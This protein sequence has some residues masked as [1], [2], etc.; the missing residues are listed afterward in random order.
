MSTLLRSSD[1]QSFLYNSQGVFD[2][3]KG[4]KLNEGELSEIRETKES[5]SDA[6]VYAIDFDTILYYNQTIGHYAVKTK[7]TK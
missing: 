2:A 6:P 3:T 1:G 7:K 4:V 5:E